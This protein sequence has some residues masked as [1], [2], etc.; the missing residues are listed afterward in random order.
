MEEEF[1]PNSFKSKEE[2]RLERR[3][4]VVS[5][6]PVVQQKKGGLLMDAFTRVKNYALSEAKNYFISTSKRTISDLVNNAT[7][8]I[9]YGDTP[10]RRKNSYQNHDNESWRYYYDSDRRPPYSQYGSYNSGYYGRQQYDERPHFD[11]NLFFPEKNYN[12]INEA[13]DDAEDVLFGMKKDLDKYKLVSV[14]TMKEYARIPGEH[15]DNNYGWTDLSK[16]YVGTVRD[17]AVL[18]LPRVVELV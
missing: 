11:G 9:L 4:P 3:K 8:I 17:G 7:S 18:Y 2:A 12:S 14:A 13:R 5:V 6:A 10:N 1:K 16:A 15:T